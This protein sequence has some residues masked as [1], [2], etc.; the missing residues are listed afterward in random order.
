MLDSIGTKK[1][2]WESYTVKDAWDGY[3]RICDARLTAHRSRRA[4]RK[5]ASRR[6]DAGPRGGCAQPCRCGGACKAV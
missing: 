5:N 2:H 6:S 3:W 4:N 1:M